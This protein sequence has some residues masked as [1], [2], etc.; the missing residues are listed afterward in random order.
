MRKAL[1]I[2]LVIVLLIEPVHANGDV[3]ADNLMPV[4]MVGSLRVISPINIPPRYERGDFGSPE[5]D[6]VTGSVELDEIVK[7]Y[8]TKVSLNLSGLDPETQYVAIYHHNPD[9]EIEIDTFDNVIQGAFVSDKE[10][11]GGALD[12]VKDSIDK[13]KSVSVRKSEDFK[14]VACSSI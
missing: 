10:G 3:L 14:T 13:I 9:C 8:D 1:I 7:N 11:K 12:T 4:L 5:Q 2:F 6:G